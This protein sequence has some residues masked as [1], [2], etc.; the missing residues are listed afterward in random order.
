MAKKDLRPAAL[1]AGLVV[2][3]GITLYSMRKKKRCTQLPDIWDEDG[4]LHLTQEAQ[5]RA[6]EYARYK[7]REYI[8]AGEVYKLSDVQMHVADSLRDCKWEK[9]KTDHQKDVWNGIR[10]IVNEVNQRVKQDHDGF[11]KSF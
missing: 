11:L 10:D 8:L 4:P 5:D 9:L 6:F 2:I 3:G 1:A 7:M